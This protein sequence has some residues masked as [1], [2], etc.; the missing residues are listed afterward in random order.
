MSVKRYDARKENFIQHRAKLYDMSISESRDW[1]RNEYEP[2]SDSNRRKIM[3]SYTKKIK[4]KYPE[5]HPAEEREE[6]IFKRPEIKKV[7]TVKQR[8]LQ[9]KRIQILKQQTRGHKTQKRVISAAIKYPYASK[10]ELQ[11]GVGSVAS[12]EYRARHKGK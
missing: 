5:R 9:I 2:A 11:H 3:R 12:K 4:E 8:K 10:Y 1:Y 6:K 7:Q